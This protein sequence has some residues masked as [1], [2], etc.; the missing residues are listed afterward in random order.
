MRTHFLNRLALTGRDVAL[1]VE[2]DFDF[3]RAKQVL[4]LKIDFD[5]DSH[6]LPSLRLDLAY[7]TPATR[8][9][10]SLLF[11]DVRELVLPAMSPSLFMPELE[12]EDLGE[13]MMEGIRFEAISQFERAFRCTCGNISIGS[14][15][16]A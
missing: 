15:E 7:E 8:Y 12:I 3:Y 11:D 6:A 5:G 9:R 2:P 1:A 4:S 16:P 14:F 10:L 13:R